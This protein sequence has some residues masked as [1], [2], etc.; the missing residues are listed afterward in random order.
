MDKMPPQEKKPSNNNWLGIFFVLV[1]IGVAF[2]SKKGNNGWIVVLLFFSFIL[3]SIFGAVLKGGRKKRNVAGVCPECRTKG[4]QKGKC[5]NPQCS[6]YD[7]TLTWAPPTAAES[8]PLPNFQGSFDPG[9]N[10]V[11]VQYRNFQGEDRTFT[12]DPK[13]LLES[14]KALSFRVAP[15]GKWIHLQKKFVKNLS[16]LKPSIPT[17]TFNESIPY[18]VDRQILSYHLK[19]KSTSPRF[20]E[21][22][23]K[24]PN[25][26]PT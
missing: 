6:K 4:A 9:P 21:L 23:R 17:G 24:Y 26:Q 13:F 5:Q 14:E 18:G 12:G 11:K 3:F 10:A 20:E 16:E 22:R 8:K 2:Y 19:K 25:W 15:T 1:F 7:A